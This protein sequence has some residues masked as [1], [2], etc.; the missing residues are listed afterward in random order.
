MHIGEVIHV[1]YVFDELACGFGMNQIVYKSNS[2]FSPSDFPLLF[3]LITH[4]EK[5]LLFC[6]TWEPEI[7]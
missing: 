4:W 6:I 7:E 5:E 1:F 2:L 3:F